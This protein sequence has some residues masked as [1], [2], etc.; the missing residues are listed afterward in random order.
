MKMTPAQIA[1]AQRLARVVEAA[2]KNHET[3]LR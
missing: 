2:M 3:E 1:E